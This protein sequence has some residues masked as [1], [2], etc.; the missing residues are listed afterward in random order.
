MKF[1]KKTQFK[2]SSGL[3]APGHLK[4]LR[5]KVEYEKSKIAD[6]NRALGLTKETNK[7]MQK[8]SET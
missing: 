2:Y 4:V 5:A 6:W 7:R 1:K 8:F 3:A